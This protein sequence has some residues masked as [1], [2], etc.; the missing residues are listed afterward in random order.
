MRTIDSIVKKVIKNLS[1]KG[2]VSWE[3]VSGAW[4]SAAGSKAAGH[5]RPVAI[6]KGVLTVNV[7]GSGWLYE[8]TIKKKEL[9]KKL[10]GKIR[11][12]TIKGIRF[13]IGEVSEKNERR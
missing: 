13:R 11:G 8:L 4:E 6:R 9:L 7:D 12:K 2:R 3:E 5:T 10:D 1:G